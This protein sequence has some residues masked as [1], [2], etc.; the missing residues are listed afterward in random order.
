MGVKVSPNKSHQHSK[1]QRRC[2]MQE[3]SLAAPHASC[4]CMMEYGK[5]G[6]TQ[7]HSNIFL[8]YSF[9]SFSGDNLD[10][11]PVYRIWKW[12][13]E[14]FKKFKMLWISYSSLIPSF[15]QRYDLFIIIRW[16]VGLLTSPM[17]TMTRNT[18]EEDTA[19]CLRAVSKLFDH[20]LLTENYFEYASSQKSVFMYYCHISVKHIYTNKMD[21]KNINIK[22]T[23]L[24]F[25][26][27]SNISLIYSPPGPPD[28]G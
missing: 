17:K 19:R 12:E 20:S 6:K 27:F 7:S 15:I 23:L 13:L 11:S 22:Q 1:A 21:E 24:F 9:D 2:F 3:C 18:A 28:P 8:T 16:L 25:W 5:A 14:S 26:C 4:M 10:F